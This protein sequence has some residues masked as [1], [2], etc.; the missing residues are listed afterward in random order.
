MTAAMEEMV[1]TVERAGCV[2][3]VEREG[4]TCLA[5]R[6]RKSQGTT[7][8]LHTYSIARMARAEWHS[9]QT[10]GRADSMLRRTR[11]MGSKI[12]VRTSS[13]V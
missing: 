10:D 13:V 5:R 11:H 12:C 7:S 6:L 8:R 1:G 4:G 9:S 2:E 3:A